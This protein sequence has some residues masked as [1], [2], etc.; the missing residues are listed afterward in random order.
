MHNQFIHMEEQRKKEQKRE[1][2]IPID[3]C[4]QLTWCWVPSKLGRTDVDTTPR[5]Y[6]CCLIGQ[7]WVYI[8]KHQL[9]KRAHPYT[10]SIKRASKGQKQPL[11]S[12]SIKKKKKDE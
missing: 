11:K 3:C 9:K 2:E 12:F 8:D 5:V 6:P 4:S 7:E 1:L 10:R